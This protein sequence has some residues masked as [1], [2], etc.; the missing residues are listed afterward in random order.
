MFKLYGNV[1]G[2]KKLDIATDEKQII[3]SMIDFSNKFNFYDYMIIQR[4]NDTDMIY[5]RIRN[6][7][8]FSAYMTEYKHR[9]KPLEDISC[10]NLKRYILK[11]KENKNDSK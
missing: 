9:I 1:A 2:W 5:K 4:E 11:K 7:E 8:E 6:Q 3:S 10:V